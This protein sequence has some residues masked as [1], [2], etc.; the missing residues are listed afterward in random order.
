MSQ[1]CVQHVAFNVRE[2]QVTG[3]RHPCEARSRNEVQPSFLYRTNS[4]PAPQGHEE[5]PRPGT[6]FL[7]SR[8][9]MRLASL[10]KISSSLMNRMIPWA[11]LIEE[12]GLG[13][14]VFQDN[15]T[16][17]VSY[18]YLAFDKR[19]DRLLF[20]RGMPPRE[21]SKTNADAGAAGAAGTPTYLPPPRLLL[22]PV[23]L[24]RRLR[25]VRA[26]PKCRKTRRQGQRRWSISSPCGT[27]LR[28]HPDKNVQLAE[29]LTKVEAEIKAAN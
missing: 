25:L 8:L 1:Q 18:T 29:R 24:L 3:L 21:Q 19:L 14:P 7:E 11:A 27:A 22:V 12:A 10:P 5:A 17:V 6:C 26:T 20:K 15:V 28:K 9:V 4:M 23:L 16:P 13:L 2:L